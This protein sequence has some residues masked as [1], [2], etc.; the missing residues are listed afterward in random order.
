MEK[1]ILKLII[2]KLNEEIKEANQ[3]FE[4]MNYENEL[5][6]HQE[7]FCDGLSCIKNI[8][9]QVFKENNFNLSEYEK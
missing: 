8:I 6:D 4:E 1:E 7:G 3:I 5:Y 9:R 2:Q